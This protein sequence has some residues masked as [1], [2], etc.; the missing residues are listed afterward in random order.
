MTVTVVAVAAF[1]SVALT[2]GFV[3]G[4]L[5]ARGESRR[6]SAEKDRTLD[7]TVRGMMAQMA[8]VTRN[9]L[10]VRGRELSEING[11]DV[12]SLLE[13]LRQQ[14]ELFRK[15][16]EESKKSNGDLN[17][18]IRACFDRLQQTADVFGVQAK[19]FTDA[20][21]GA[22][23]KQGNWGENILGRMLEDCGLRKGEHFLSQTGSGSGIPDY[24]VF[25]PCGKKILVI[26]AKMSWTKYEQAYAMPDGAARSSAL[27]EHVASV[28]RHVDELASA[29][30]PHRQV[31]PRAGYEYVP[32]TAMFVPCD[33]ALAAA[34]AEDPSIVDYAFRR[35]VALVSPLTLFGFMLLVSRAWSRYNAERNSEEIFKQA[36]LLVERVDKMFRHFE[37]V[38]MCLDKAR[39]KH[40]A[41]MRLATTDVEGSCIKGPALKILKLGGSPERELKSVAMTGIDGDT[42]P[43]NQ[44]PD[45]I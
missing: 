23:K 43:P 18:T 22:N 19:S 14:L 27:K 5:F 33:A 9:E 11:R 8:N 44:T 28:K 38:G 4:L 24:Q 40:N 25:D 15:T 12:K 16:A 21:T 6:I 42:K 37:D 34:L 29:D 41:V 45:M 36:R 30:Y 17:V 32:L 31:S 13:P 10:A 26:D 2:V 7:E 20:L 3:L 1:V 35:N 39:E